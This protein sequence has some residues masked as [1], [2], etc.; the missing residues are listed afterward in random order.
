MYFNPK[1]RDEIHQLDFLRVADLFDETRKAWNIQKLHA[2]FYDPLIEA[3]L[4]IP[5]SMF[6]E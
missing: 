3:I 2:I 4:K 1:P 5:I 6:F